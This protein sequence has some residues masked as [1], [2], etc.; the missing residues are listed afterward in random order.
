MSTLDILV[1]ASSLTAFPDCERRFAARHLQDLV[2]VA[3]F[4]LRT[5]PNNIGA[6]V[7]TAT[8]AG[9]AHMLKHKIATGETSSAADAIEQGI[10][11]LRT[12][13]AEGAVWDDTTRTMNEAEQQTMRMVSIYHLLV[14]PQIKPVAVEQ[15][16]TARFSGTLRLT[17]HMDV[18]EDEEIHDTKTGVSQRPNHPQYGSYSMLRRAN[19][20]TVNRF[21]ED[22]VP[23]TP[24]KRLQGE[25]KMTEY[26][27]ASCEQ[28]AHH[29][30]KRIDKAAQD[31]AKDGDPW[32]FIPNPA[33]M[34]C[35]DKFCPAHSSGFCRV[36]K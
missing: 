35:S 24:I 20:H 7:G 26:P 19:G 25:P 10:E 12:E 30:L 28:S 22:Y 36:H 14:A 27:V 18:A 3:G 21:V 11:S 5:V 32:T 1:R 9:A 29:I 17:G 4:Q 34:L 31:F 15:E 2:E 8:H 13:V 16:M 23:R 33:S 6:K